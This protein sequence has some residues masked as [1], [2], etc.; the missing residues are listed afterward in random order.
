[1]FR[2]PKNR[3]IRQRQ[4]DFGDDEVNDGGGENEEAKIK[5]EVKEEPQNV[6]EDE[7]EAPIIFSKPLKKP[8]AM[9]SFNEDEGVDVEEFKIKKPSHK[10]RAEKLAKRQKELEEREKEQKRAEKYKI[11]EEIGIVVKNSIKVTTQEVNHETVEDDPVIIAAIE[12]DLELRTKFGGFDGIPDAKAVYEAKKRRE[13]MRRDGTKSKLQNNDSGFIP[14]STN[15]TKLEKV[16]HSRLVREDENDMSDEDGEN[17]QQFYSSKSLL[18]SEEERRRK[19]QEEFLQL[20]GDDSD[21]DNGNDDEETA[22]ANAEAKRRAQESDDEFAEWEKHQI[23]K[24]VSTQKVKQMRQ[25]NYAINNEAPPETVEDGEE[26]MDI[27]IIDE[28]IGLKGGNVPSCSQTSLTEI[29]EKLRKR[30][31][32]KQEFIDSQKSELLRKEANVAENITLISGI[33]ADYPILR[34][35]YRL[36]QEMR[37]FTKD[38]LDC[39]NEKIDTINSVENQI[40]TMWKNR[41]EKIMK[42]R[43]ADIQDQYQRC[44]AA[45]FGRAYQP[46]ADVIQRETNCNGRRSSRRNQREKAGIQDRHHDGLSSDEEEPESQKFEYQRTIG[47]LTLVF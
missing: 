16:A 39:I 2:K 5:V 11:D 38:L 26:D 24:A 22:A 42:R 37:I 31:Q 43:R 10:K 4:R 14:L 7:D 40:F 8:P 32:D 21:E 29:M 6:E 25:E 1:M 18:M 45:A 34:E 30:V 12:Q 41:A 27:E 28:P 47:K 46:S 23:R 19:E 35:K 9:L 17:A 3:N 15:T 13:Q 36:Y 20:E 44:Y 33:E